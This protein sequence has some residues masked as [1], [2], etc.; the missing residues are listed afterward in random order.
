MVT[1]FS[2]FIHFGC[3]AAEQL[4]EPVA[5]IQEIDVNV[6][7]L[8]G[9]P[10]VRST[11]LQYP[12]CDH[13]FRV[14]RMVL[15]QDVQKA[16]QRSTRLLGRG[17]NGHRTHGQDDNRNKHSAR[18]HRPAVIVGLLDRVE[19][20]QH[21]TPILR[22]SGHTEQQ[23]V[24]CQCAPKHFYTRQVRALLYTCIAGCCDC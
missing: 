21:S 15:A 20:L 24:G 14:H 7:L 3:L 4:F 22:L 2:R 8:H 6:V 13:E 1:H 12:V 18:K 5:F 17:R 11:K 16:K 19:M 23:S 9:V 10:I